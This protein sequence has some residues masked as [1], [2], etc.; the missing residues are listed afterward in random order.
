[1]VIR[2]C[3][4][5]CTDRQTIDSNVTGRMVIANWVIKCTDANWYGDKEMCTVLY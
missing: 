2:K 5:F 4:Q 1:M 3:V